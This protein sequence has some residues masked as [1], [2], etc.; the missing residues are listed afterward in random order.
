MKELLPYYGVPTYLPYMGGMGWIL[1]PDVVKWIA[2]SKLQPTLG[3]PEDAYVGLWL[4][5]F[6]LT[7]KDDREG[8]HDVEHGGNIAPCTAKS[9][10]LHHMKPHLWNRIDDKGDLQC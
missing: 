10:L 6:D 7:W 9:I 3:N 5:G 4:T 1:T 2:E 8:F